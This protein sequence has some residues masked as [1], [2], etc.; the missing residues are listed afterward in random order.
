MLVTH[1]LQYLPRKEVDR[2]GLLAGGRL[3]GPA[4]WARL[5]ATC[6]QAEEPAV[7]Q[8]VLAVAQA[9]KFVPAQL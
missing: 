9:A 3:V 7:A 2:V 6:T 5:A 1:Q 8:L 4:P